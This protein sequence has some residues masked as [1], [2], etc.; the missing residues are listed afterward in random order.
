M[1]V[2]HVRVAL[3][4][5]YSLI[6]S[7]LL[8]GFVATMVLRE[9]CVSVQFFM[10]MVFYCTFQILSLLCL[11]FWTSLINLATYQDKLAKKVNFFLLMLRP[12]SSHT[13]F[14]PSR[15]LQVDSNILFCFFSP[16]LNNLFV[17]NFQPL[18]DKTKL[19]MSR[20]V[21]LPLSLVGCIN[22]V[23][24]V[25]LPKFLYLFQHI[26]IC[27]NKSFFTKFDGT[28]HSFRWGNKPACLK[29]N[30][31]FNFLA[32]PNFQRY[33]WACK[34]NQILYWNSSIHA[35]T[36]PSWAHI[37]IASL[38][39]SLYSV[40]FSQLHLAITK[41]STNPVVTSTIKIWVQFRKHF[42]LHR[43]SIYTSILNSHLFTPSCSD[44]AFRIW[45][46]NGLVTLNDLYVDG[47]FT[48]FSFLS[49]KYN[50]P[51]SHLFRGEFQYETS[52]ILF[53]LLFLI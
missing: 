17:K 24:M 25:T 19:D 41:I 14:F 47:V 43:A 46:I 39:S 6:Q 29:K 52:C 22:L 18:V 36:C 21:L 10:L 3:F 20:W 34:I 30:Q 26:S 40:I 33:Y 27:I 49:T 37:E 9:F 12:K 51:S 28:L 35:E 5:L 32:L 7:L 23:K 13:F 11:L 44:P 38:K 50:L 16:I 53:F 4:H 15:L 1:F 48:S 2:G 45:S 8:S 31:F 42:G